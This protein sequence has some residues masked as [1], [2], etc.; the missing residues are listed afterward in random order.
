MGASA[1]AGHV[2]GCWLLHLK[3]FGQGD[4]FHLAAGGEAAV[5]GTVPVGSG[6]QVNEAAGEEERKQKCSHSLTLRTLGYDGD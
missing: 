1:A 4:P 3:P 2:A 6:G 5:T